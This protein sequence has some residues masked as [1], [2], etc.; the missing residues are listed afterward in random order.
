MCANVARSEYRVAGYKPGTRPASLFQARK[1]NGSA[2]SI[3][4]RGQVATRQGLRKPRQ[5]TRRHQRHDDKEGG[6]VECVHEWLLLTLG[7]KLRERSLLTVDRNDR[8]FSLNGMD[9]Q[10][11]DDEHDRAACTM[12]GESL[13]FRPAR[14]QNIGH[15]AK[16]DDGEDE[17]NYACRPAVRGQ[18]HG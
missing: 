8:T 6:Y 18:H 1:Q 2:F 4:V 10:E 3:A 9:Q 13:Q 11:A 17:Q 14:T 7:L 12:N 16:R 5:R 15:I